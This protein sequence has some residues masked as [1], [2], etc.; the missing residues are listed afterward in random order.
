[1]RENRLFSG[2]IY[3]ADKMF[4]LPP[5]VMVVTNLTSAQSPSFIDENPLRQKGTVLGELVVESKND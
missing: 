1:M 5:V 2:E 4:T 3:T